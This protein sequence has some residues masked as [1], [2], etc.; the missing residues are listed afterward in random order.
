MFRRQS[1]AELLSNEATSASQS[2]T[3][4]CYVSRGNSW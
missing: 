3:A 4:C 2:P 1:W